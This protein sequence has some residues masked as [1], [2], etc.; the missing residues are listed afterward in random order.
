MAANL[1]VEGVGRRTLKD[2][3]DKT[4][5]GKIA[6]FFGNPG[7]RPT[8]KQQAPIVV[9]EDL[10]VSDPVIKTFQEERASLYSSSD[11]SNQEFG[12]ITVGQNG[13]ITTSQG[14]TGLEGADGSYTGLVGDGRWF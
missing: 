8:V 9:P 4:G 11:D 12:T 3:E 7:K 5:M 1:P 6:R 14:F 2:G 10:V 13:S